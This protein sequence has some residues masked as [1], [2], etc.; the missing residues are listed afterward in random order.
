MLGT[1]VVV[2]RPRNKQ[3]LDNSISVILVCTNDFILEGDDEIVAKYSSHS[4][5]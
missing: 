3:A 4:N 1:I 2:G 5:N